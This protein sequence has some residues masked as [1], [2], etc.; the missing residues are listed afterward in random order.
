MRRPFVLL[1]LAASMCSALGVFAQD[2]LIDE[3]THGQVAQIREPRGRSVFPGPRNG[4]AAAIIINTSEPL[5]SD[6]QSLVTAFDSD[7]AN[8]RQKAEQ[9]IQAKRQALIQSLQTLQDS[10]TRDA[11]LDE[12]VAIRDTIR[13]LKASGL[14][15]LPDPGNLAAYVN[16]IGET[17]YFDV[18]GR[19]SGSAWG[20]EV[21]TYDSDLGTAAVHAGVLKVGQRGLVK[22]TM[23][24][25]P[26]AH[27]GSTQNGVTTSNWGSFSASYTV[28]RPFT[29]RNPP[30]LSSK[31]GFPGTVSATPK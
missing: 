3:A 17:I 23:H 24:K 8:I 7:S 11:R 28:E 5:P 14:K 27:R 20:S 21:Y 4:P 9:E 12:A 19:N 31:P 26:D 2:L 1:A 29:D 16:Q 18:V 10:Y 25:S 13:Q 30:P 6:A 22:V 15:A